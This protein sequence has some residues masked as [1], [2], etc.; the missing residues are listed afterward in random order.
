MRVFLTGGTGYLGGQLLEGLLD[1]G[2][3]VS[4][5]TR[6]P[7]PE[8]ERPGLRWVLGDLEEHLPDV[9][10]F[11]RHSVVVHSA[12]MVKTW[13]PDA[14]EFD[15]VNVLAYQKLLERCAVAGVTKIVHTSSF[16][17]LGPSPT[18]SPIDEKNRVERTHFYTDYE[19]T[20]YL[21][22]QV[23]DRYLD[24][25]LPI[26]TVYPTILF[27]P[28]KCTDGNLLGKLAYWVR[29]GTFPGRIGS[30]NQVWN[31]AFVPD[32]VAGHVA[33]VERGMGGHRFILGGE[34]ISLND[35]LRM[36]FT[37]LDKPLKMRTIP[38]PIAEGL[39]RLM[40][41]GARFTK[42]APELTRGAAGAY[43]E[44][45]AYTSKRAERALGYKITPFNEA[46]DQTLE[47]VRGLDRW[48]DSA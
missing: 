5:L 7:R 12:A 18:P 4:A 11:N 31:Y 28:G 46:L 23:T 34:N 48:G 45:W 17:S 10:E 27:G 3:E 16:F 9:T 32:V 2:H 36:I 44:H 20:K 38:V 33:A 35:L 6:R 42:K 30:G 25:G 26:V 19:R 41:F 13:A 43:R 21:A 39:G 14:G 29:E 37:K 47:W 15:R 8:D 1:A 24:K 40:E 22:D